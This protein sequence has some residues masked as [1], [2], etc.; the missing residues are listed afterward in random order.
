MCGIVKNKKE[1][2]KAIQDKVD[3][4]MVYST[5]LHVH[6]VNLTITAIILLFWGYI[7]FSQHEESGG[8]TAPDPDFFSSLDEA[9]QAE[10]LAGGATFDGVDRN[11]TITFDSGSGTAVLGNGSSSIG[12]YYLGLGCKEGERG[13][14]TGDDF[15]IGYGFGGWYTQSKPGTKGYS[16]TLVDAMLKDECK[17]L[18]RDQALTY[19]CERG[20]IHANTYEYMISTSDACQYEVDLINCGIWKQCIQ[21]IGKTVF[22][23]ETGD[24]EIPKSTSDEIWRSCTQSG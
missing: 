20:I 18:T 23:G 15:K 14:G 10:F 2:S 8:S 9:D 21:N 1:D 12:C 3:N 22:S 13:R 19:F 17:G 4:T 16:M 6:P 11:E 7:Y 5:M 24:V